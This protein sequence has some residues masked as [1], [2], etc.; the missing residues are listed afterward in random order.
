MTAPTGSPGATGSGAD[1]PGPAAEARATSRSFLRELPVIV[2]V[3]LALSLLL[4]TFLVQAFFIPSTSMQPTLEVGDRVFVEKIT[5]RFGSVDRGDVIVFRDPGGWLPDDPPA[6]RGVR[7]ALREAL[8]FVGVLPSTSE[9]DLIK[10]VIGVGGDRV[11]CCDRDGRVTVNGKALD[12]PYVFPG[13]KPSEIDFDV[14]V[15]DGSVWVMG[16]HRGVSEDS[17]FHRDENGGRIPLDSVI[18]RAFVTVWPADR[19]G[20]LGRPAQFE[21]LDGGAGE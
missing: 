11:R 10:R 14:R 5:T 1:D 9:D 3:A 2:V 6:P 4:K 17:R 20:G 8:A 12:E 21:R 13:D 15:P 7:T 16:D 18:G 19:W